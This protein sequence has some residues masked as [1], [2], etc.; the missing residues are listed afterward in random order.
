VAVLS[1]AGLKIQAAAVDV[2]GDDARIQ[3]RAAEFRGE[4]HPEHKL[5]AESERKA[6]A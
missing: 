4:D 6:A 1:V 5:K 2:W 3:A